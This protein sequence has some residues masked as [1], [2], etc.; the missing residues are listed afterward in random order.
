M[1][2]K[3]G[4]KMVGLKKAVS[5]MPGENY[6]GQYVQ[7]NYD[8]RDGQILANYH[9]SLGQN[10]W[11]EYHDKEIILIGNYQ[12]ATMQEL[13]DAIADTVIMR[14][15]EEQNRAEEMAALETNRKEWEANHP[16]G[17]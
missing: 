13:A 3:H 17:Y 7:I 6:N 8:K 2:N 4:Y 16:Y 14:E 5:A 1:T 10:S 12:T 11:T 9:V 15:A